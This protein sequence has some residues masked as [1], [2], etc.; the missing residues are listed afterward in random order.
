MR[1]AEL[2]GPAARARG[3]DRPAVRVEGDWEGWLDFF[4]DGG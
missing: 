4:L 2:C 3:E 1:T